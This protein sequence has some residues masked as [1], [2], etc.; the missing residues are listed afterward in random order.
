MWSGTGKETLTEGIRLALSHLKGDFF[1]V[2][3]RWLSIQV[4]TILLENGAQ[5]PAGVEP[6]VLKSNVIRTAIKRRKQAMSEDALAHTLKCRFQEGFA[7]QGMLCNNPPIPLRVLDF[8][9]H[10]PDLVNLALVSKATHQ[11]GHYLLQREVRRAHAS[12]FPA[13]C[14]Y[15]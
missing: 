15:P 8:L 13:P 2:T 1:V 6:G 11:A 7:S 3:F 4:L 10:T 5:F 9:D 12:L 14:S